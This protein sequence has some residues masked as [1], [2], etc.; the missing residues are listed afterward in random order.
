MPGVM[1]PPERHPSRPLMLA[2]GTPHRSSR[3]LMSSDAAAF[4]D[5]DF[6]LELKRV[7]WS[8]VFVLAAIL[9]FSHFTR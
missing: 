4:A 8:G 5:F 2:A 7:L 9:Y 1:A 6:E 3:G